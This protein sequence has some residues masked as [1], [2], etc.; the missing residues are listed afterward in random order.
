MRQKD[1]K[2]PPKNGRDL[3]EHELE[4]SSPQEDF[5]LFERH[6]IQQNVSKAA[7]MKIE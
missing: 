7:K 1:K 5:L 4:I 2:T 6:K 3:T